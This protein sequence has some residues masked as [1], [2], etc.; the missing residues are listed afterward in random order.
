MAKSESAEVTTPAHSSSCCAVPILVGV[1]GALTFGVVAHR[2][3]LC[4]D[5]K[6]VRKLVNSFYRV[7]TL[8]LK[9]LLGKPKRV[10]YWR[11]A[12]EAAAKKENAC[13]GGSGENNAG[14]HTGCC[15]GSHHHPTVGDHSSQL[16]WHTPKKKIRNPYHVAESG[17]EDADVAWL[18]ATPED[19]GKSCTGGE[20]SASTGVSNE[21]G[22]RELGLVG[23]TFP[24]DEEEAGRAGR[25]VRA[26][27]PED[28][29]PADADDV[30]HSVYVTEG[31]ERE[32]YFKAFQ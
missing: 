14:H 26:F 28:A 29:H 24:K 32:R 22:L 6:R 27:P 4:D 20:G 2:F 7:R 9:K 15:G 16:K 25:G 23:G 12:E 21:Q 8:L 31:E 17:E 13:C 18:E 19:M 30:F 10:D 5:Q 1:T 11:A 3:L